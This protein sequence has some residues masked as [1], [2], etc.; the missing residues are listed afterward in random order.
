M[1]FFSKIILASNII[2]AGL[3]TQTLCA[4]ISAM[5]NPLLQ[6]SNLQYQ[7]PAFNLIKGEHFKPAFEEGLKKPRCGN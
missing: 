6:R 2:F 4:Q 7:A 5:N 3:Y 1:T